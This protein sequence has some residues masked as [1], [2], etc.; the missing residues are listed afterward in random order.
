MPAPDK[1]LLDRNQPLHRLAC[2]VHDI[3]TQAW[4]SSTFK[5][6]ISFITKPLD[7]GI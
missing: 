2:Q 3:G 5:L 6:A 7:R 4:P 1:Y